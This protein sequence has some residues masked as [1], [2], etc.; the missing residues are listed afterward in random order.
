MNMSQ[1]ET[2]SIVHAQGDIAAAVRRAIDLAGGL[3][4][5]AGKQVVLKPNLMCPDNGGGH[6]TTDCRVTEAVAV[7]A[8]E[9]GARVTIAEGAAVGFI[10]PTDHFDT[11]E[12]YEVTG[13][14]AMARRLGIAVVDLNRE[15]FEEVPLSGHYA[16]ATVPLPRTIREADLVISVP[17]FKVHG[18]SGLTIACKN[19]QGVMPWREKRRTHRV[20]LDAGLSDINA[21]VMPGFTVVDGVVAQ[22]VEG[23]VP[24]DLVLAG[25][26]CTAVDATCARIVGFPPES[27]ALLRFNAER[28]LGPIDEGQIEVRGVPVA[29]VKTAWS[30]PCSESFKK[31]P[32]VSWVVRDPYPC[33]ACCY[34]ANVGLGYVKSVYGAA[35]LAGL[36]LALGADPT[37]GPREEVDIVVGDCAQQWASGKIV[38]GGRAPLP[39]TV[40]AEICWLRDL[41]PEP[42]IK[43]R[44]RV[45]GSDWAD[46]KRVSEGG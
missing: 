21:A 33:S 28:C 4:P 6:Q 22:S 38:V 35:P 11:L 20:G 13:H 5:M 32:E 40:A 27:V 7:A 26:N 45:V 46:I 10:G 31:T 44:K 42:A 17:Y 23:P 34:A 43:M 1:K 8:L 19:F 3:P 41:D 36:R 14:A 29:E 24:L 15:G 9:A 39:A 18:F 16:M 30:W 12:A 2:V 25:R 37:G